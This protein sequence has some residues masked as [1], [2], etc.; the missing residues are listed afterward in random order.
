[1]TQNFRIPLPGGDRSSNKLTKVLAFD[2]KSG[3]RINQRQNLISLNS[4]PIKIAH[5]GDDR[6]GFLCRHVGDAGA[7]QTIFAIGGLAR[8]I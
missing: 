6:L 3:A 2:G 4:I 1:M 5:R 8:T 7:H